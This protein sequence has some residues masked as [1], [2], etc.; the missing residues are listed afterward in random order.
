M[1]RKSTKINLGGIINTKRSGEYKFSKSFAS[2]D[3]AYIA[4]HQWYE[5][6]VRIAI[7]KFKMADKNENK[8][9][10]HVLSPAECFKRLMH[11]HLTPFYN[12]LKKQLTAPQEFFK[13][14]LFGNKDVQK[15]IFLNQFELN[16]IYEGYLAERYEIYIDND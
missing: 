14:E 1:K 10:W 4:R 16:K 8:T 9:D 12:R 6:L 13:R 2:E 11:D 7:K 5:L 3:S 15:Y